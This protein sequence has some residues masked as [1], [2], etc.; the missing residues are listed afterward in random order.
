MHFNHMWLLYRSLYSGVQRQMDKWRVFVP[1]ILVGTVWC[2]MTAVHSNYPQWK[3]IAMNVT[4]LPLALC[5]FKFAI[6]IFQLFHVQIYVVHKG[7]MPLFSYVITQTELLEF[8]IYN[9]VW[10]KSR[11][12]SCELLKRANVFNWFTFL[13]ILVLFIWLATTP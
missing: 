3:W 12:G 13:P 11:M 8:T 10:C 1:K 5:C 7:T 9:A 4:D 2:P 6:V